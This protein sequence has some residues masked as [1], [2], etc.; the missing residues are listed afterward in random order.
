M[1]RALAEQYD[2]EQPVIEAIR[3][4][5]RYAFSELVQR[6]D[7]WIRAVVFGVLGRSDAVDDV[8]Q[9]IWASVWQRIG[10]LRD[11]Q[12]WRSWLYRMARNAA[13]DAGREITRRRRLGENTRPQTRLERISTP[14]NGEVDRDEQRREVLMAIEGLPAIYREPFVL[15]HLNDWSYQ[16]IA[17]VMDMPVDSIETRLVRARR[18][19]REVLR[20]KVG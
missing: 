18:L 17:D 10:E 6:H 5:D 12:R 14:P 13:L 20:D 8:V 7:R 3:A 4:G 19:L 9:Q 2:A 1:S 15:R 16:E 11:A